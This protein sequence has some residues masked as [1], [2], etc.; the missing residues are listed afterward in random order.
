MDQFQFWKRVLIVMRFH[1]LNFTGRQ[2]FL[3]EN[4]L[5]ARLILEPFQTTFHF[6]HVHVQPFGDGW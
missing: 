2:S 4:R 6:F 5:I 1:K 3:D